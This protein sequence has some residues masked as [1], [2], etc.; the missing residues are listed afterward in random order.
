MLPHC[1]DYSKRYTKSF[2]LRNIYYVIKNSYN[3]YYEEIKNK[4]IY[5]ILYNNYIRYLIN[6]Y[7]SPF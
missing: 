1:P 3:S 5:F 7:I 2:I 6:Y 4:K